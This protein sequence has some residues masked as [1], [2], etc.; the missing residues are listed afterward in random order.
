MNWDKQILQRINFG[1]C[2]CFNVE[3]PTCS[4]VQ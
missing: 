4:L 3:E 1:N 2:V